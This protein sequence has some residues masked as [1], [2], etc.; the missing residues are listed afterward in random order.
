MCR[1]SKRFVYFLILRNGCTIRDSSAGVGPEAEC[2]GLCYGCRSAF[3]TDV[4][5]VDW[6]CWARYKSPRPH[7]IRG[8]CAKMDTP[9][10]GTAYLYFK[11]TPSPNTTLPICWRRVCGEGGWLMVRV[12]CQPFQKGGFN[13]GETHLRLKVRA[14]TTL[15]VWSG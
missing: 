5:S 7:V 14:R 15:R 12:T 10:V 13:S 3:K 8:G 11:N 1:S 4:V 2:E 6:S 9:S